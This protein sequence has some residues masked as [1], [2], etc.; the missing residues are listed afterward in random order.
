M[1]FAARALADETLT[2]T[3]RYHRDRLDALFAGR[4]LEHPFALSGLTPGN[5]ATALFARMN[6]DEIHHLDLAYAPPFGPVYD[7][8]LDIC[9]KAT[10]EL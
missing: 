1:P 5:L 4:D 7:A 3:Y 8:I 2:D 10:L 6:I 9:G